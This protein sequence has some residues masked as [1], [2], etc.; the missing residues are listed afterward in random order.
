MGSNAK[1]AL[2]KY[3]W[4][5]IKHC[6][7]EIMKKRNP[8][9]RME[10]LVNRFDFFQSLSYADQ[11]ICAEWIKEFNKWVPTLKQD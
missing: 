10:R 7:L 8:I 6:Y 4:M 9:K 11:L 3:A 5:T 1:T 2:D